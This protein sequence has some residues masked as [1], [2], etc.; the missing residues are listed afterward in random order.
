[1]QNRRRATRSMLWTFAVAAPTAM[2]AGCQDENA[3]PGA[4]DSV[5]ATSTNLAGDDAKS[6]SD[7]AA[8]T[9]DNIATSTTGQSTENSAAAKPKL[10]PGAKTVALSRVGDR[11][12]DKTFDD[13][14]FDIQPGDPFHREMLPDSIEA[15]AGQRIRIRGYILP[16]PQKRGIKQFVLVRD[17]Q[18]CCFGPGAAIYDCILVEMQPGK[19]AEFSIR[20]VAVE[21]TFDIEEILG[22]DDK[23]LAIYHMEGESVR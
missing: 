14:R 23:H 9:G 20:P 15:L 7:P 16:T 18:E 10:R 12:Y 21:G 22:P 5:T 6:A 1:M 19:T 17:N 13:I 4:A 11:P 3:R 8:T 2:L